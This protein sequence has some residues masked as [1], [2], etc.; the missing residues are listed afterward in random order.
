MKKVNNY[1][2]L[3]LKLPKNF[4]RVIQEEMLDEYAI[5]LN[6]W[7]LHLNSDDKQKILDSSIQQL[8]G[9]VNNVSGS[10]WDIE[11]DEL[12][13]IVSMTKTGQTS[14]DL[15]STE[16]ENYN[17]KLIRAH[18]GWRVDNDPNT[19]AVHIKDFYDFIIQQV[20]TWARTAVFYG[21]G[22]YS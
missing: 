17:V 15:P 10:E 2:D 4:K 3:T 11:T 21:V 1:L 12:N 19:D 20:K 7:G 14:I 8:I 6:K 22:S 16:A 13:V 9:K 5:A 18:D